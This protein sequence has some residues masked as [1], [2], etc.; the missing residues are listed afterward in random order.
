MSMRTNC[1]V[2]P[3]VRRKISIVQFPSQTFSVLQYFH[4]ILS[5]IMYSLNSQQYE[6][7][8]VSAAQWL[9]NLCIVF[10][11]KS[12]DSKTDFLSRDAGWNTIQ[13]LFALMRNDGN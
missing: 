4:E 13:Y 5:G 6:N 1:L 3:A 12:V 2:S 10:W 8:F 11:H 7:S 9:P